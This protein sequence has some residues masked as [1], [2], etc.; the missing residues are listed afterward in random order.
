M[1]SS[2]SRQLV[3]W[4][5]VP[6]T[7]LALAGV[8]MHYFNNLAP[9]VITIDHHLKDASTA[10]VH[11]LGDGSGDATLL[12]LTTEDHGIRF[13]IRDSTRS[14][15]AG[16]ARLPVAPRTDGANPL[17]TTPLNSRAANLRRGTVS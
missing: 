1:N 16:D 4:L 11:Q 3:L 8:L 17:Y 12:A 2:I 9:Q 7:L 6:L 10:L 14:L 13:A 5:T 15:I